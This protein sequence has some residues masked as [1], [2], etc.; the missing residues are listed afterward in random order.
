MAY[1][2]PYKSK[3]PI[4]PN[5]KM[6]DGSTSD[7][8]KYLADYNVN[9]PIYGNVFANANQGFSPEARSAFRTEMTSTLPSQYEAAAKNMRT[10]L[11]RTGAMGGTL[12]PDTGQILSG[13]APLEQGFL[14]TRSRANRETI[15]ADEALQERNRNAAAGVMSGAL[16]G[17]QGAVNSLAGLESTSM[18]NILAASLLGTGMK[19]L[20]DPVAAK[21]LMS[22]ISKIPG[23]EKLFPGGSLPEGFLDPL[24]GAL[25]RS[26]LSQLSQLAGIADM[27]GGMNIPGVDAIPITQLATEAGMGPAGAVAGQAAGSAGAQAAT[28]AGTTGAGAAA[29]AAGAGAKAIAFLTNPWTIGVGAGLVLATV[30]LKSQAHHEANTV[31]KKIENPFWDSF[32]KILPTDRPEELAAMPPAQAAQ[33]KANLV[34]MNRNYLTLIAEYRKGGKD[35]NK[36]STQSL[37][38]T[39]PNINRM[40]AALDLAIARGGAV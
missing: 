9:N 6:P 30:W 17:S 3:A 19:A 12:P 35:E 11:L 28:Q 27:A 20:T 23:L 38:N 15:M 36:V 18:K 2:D 4:D 29:G 32:L 22:T 13:F 37:N 8:L 26:G 16:S 1:Y 21:A 5:F 34:A 7:R 24:T 25:S 33:I 40:I 31:V 10:R 39:Q 14:E